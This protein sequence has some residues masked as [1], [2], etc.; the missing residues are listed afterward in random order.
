MKEEKKDSLLRIRQ[1]ILLRMGERRKTRVLT[2]VHSKSLFGEESFEELGREE[3]E[4]ILMRLSEIEP[5]QDIDLILHTPGG[6]TL[7]AEMI[8]IALKQ[9][10]GKVNVIVPFYAMSGGTLIALSADQIMMNRFSVL[11]PC[12]PQIGG[13]PA[14]VLLKIYREKG[15][16]FT[17]DETVMYAYIAEMAI[18]RTRR[19]L[20]YLLKGKMRSA[21]IQKI[22]RFFLEG[23][24]THDT[25]ITYDVLR[26]LNLPVVLEIPPEV[27]D[28]LDTCQFGEC[29]RP[30]LID[31][32]KATLPISPLG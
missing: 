16:Q 30:M 23:Y 24:L 31:Y 32:G 22:S 20:A 11:G 5:T 28:F 4:H 26:K 25:P 10:R 14:S 7:A 2:I 19:F 6:M 13:W 15:V 29:A 18:E 12:D 3:T 27:Y 9:H 8:A 21:Q 17:S 1:E